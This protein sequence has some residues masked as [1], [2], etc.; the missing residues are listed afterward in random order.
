MKIFKKRRWMTVAILFLVLIFL[1]QV[2][3]YFVR[4]QE[5][6]AR[7]FI[8][9]AVKKAYPEAALKFE[10]SKGLSPFVPSSD[11]VLRESLGIVILIHGLDEPG[12]IWMNLAPVLVE[13]G[14]EVLIMT[15]PNDQPIRASTQFFLKEISSYFKGNTRAVSIVAHSM[16][17]LITRDLLTNPM[18]SYDKK[19]QQG[20]VPK[21]ERLIMVGT[22]NHGAELAQF[23]FFLEIR[24]QFHQFFQKDAHWLNFLLDGGGEAGIDL[25]PHSRFIKELNHRPPPE[26]TQFDI[27]AGSVS[28]WSKED[29]EA[30]VEKIQK[31]IPE[32][33]HGAIALGDILF[34]MIN[35]IGDTL[36]SVD[37]AGLDQVP[38]TIVPGSHL[39][40]IRNFSRDSTRIPPAVPVIVQKLMVKK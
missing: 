29:I 22:P 8:H 35:I 34:S 16:G 10:K 36:V 7:N 25:L 33:S 15:Y 9:T 20:K 14:F 37:S 38:L 6:Q 17:G 12:L 11:K 40:M 2:G 39:T 32:G 27:I 1:I 5:W 3:R 30:L 4:D 24:D 21:I 18:F 28:P 26:N 23:R 13:K 19:A 31:N